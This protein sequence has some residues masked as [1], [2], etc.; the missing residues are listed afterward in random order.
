MNNNDRRLLGELKARMED[1]VKGF[2]EMKLDIKFL[3]KG[4]YKQEEKL[5]GFNIMFK[6]H[7]THHQEE[8]ERSQ[9]RVKILL[10]AITALASVLTAF[11]FLVGLG[12]I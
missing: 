7:L 5:V 1:L 9:R 11:G 8:A 10:G 12:V 3:V 6:N 2:D 4:H